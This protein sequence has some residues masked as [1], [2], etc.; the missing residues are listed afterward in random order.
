MPFFA[1]LPKALLERACERIVGIVVK[2]LV[3]PET[4]D[5]RRNVADFSAQPAECGEVLI[6]NLEGRQC[7]WQRILVELRIGF[8]PRDLSD[9]HNASDM[10]TTQER[11]EILKAAVGMTDREEGMR[12]SPPLSRVLEGAALV[13]SNM[14]GLIA[15]YLVLWFVCRR[16]MCVA[17][18]VE[19]T[20]VNS[21]DGSRHQARL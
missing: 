18:V 6:G 12:L 16:T 8:R 2:A 7:L 17:F 4:I 9:V 19:I 13:S 20:G 10:G 1:Q 14:V 15:S 3:G 5:L 11:N 21:Y